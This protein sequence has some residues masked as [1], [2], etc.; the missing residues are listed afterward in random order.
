MAKTKLLNDI[1][2]QTDIVSKMM[3][4]LSNKLA[5][6]DALEE[7]HWKGLS[8]LK[9]EIDKLGVTISK[10]NARI[11]EWD[12][13]TKL[14]DVFKNKA[15]LAQ[16]RENARKQAEVIKQNKAGIDSDFNGIVK[17]MRELGKN[18]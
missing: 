4:S 13:S 15:K 8:D 9:T 12:G 1:A 11:K 6:A 7:A 17:A 2:L 18:G 5:T 16:A 14:R 3:L 10:L